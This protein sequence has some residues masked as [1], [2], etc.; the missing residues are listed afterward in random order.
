MKSTELSV[1]PTCERYFERE[2]TM[3]K[4]AVHLNSFTRHEHVLV[5]RRSKMTH[6]TLDKVFDGTLCK[7]VVHF[8]ASLK[9]R[10]QSHLGAVE[11]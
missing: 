3:I 4:A 9:Q 2:E 10:C 6:A 1:H 5:V 7:F 8:R 11:K